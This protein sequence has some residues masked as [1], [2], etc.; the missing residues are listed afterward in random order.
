VSL[1]GG[2]IIRQSSTGDFFVDGDNE[3][4]HIHQAD[5]AGAIT[6]LECEE[7]PLF[8]ICSEVSMF[9]NVVDDEWKGR[10]APCTDEGKTKVG[11]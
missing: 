4:L 1:I 10:R 9:A 8:I 5:A 7:H 6:Q 2:A 3:L 11:C